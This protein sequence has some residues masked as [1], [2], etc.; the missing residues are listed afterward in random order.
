MYQFP[1][2][3]IVLTMFVDRLSG[4][5]ALG[6]RK[7]ILPSFSSPMLLQSYLSYPSV[8]LYL[9]QICLKGLQVLRK[10]I[11]CNKIYQF[12]NANLIIEHCSKNTFYPHIFSHF[13]DEI[14]FTY[15]IQH[16]SSTDKGKITKLEKLPSKYCF[17]TK[18]GDLSS[19]FSHRN[20]FYPHFL[21]Q[22]CCSD[23]WAIHLWNYTW[24]KYV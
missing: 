18:G 7:L 11:M 5:D 19:F 16:K 2:C 12:Q 17:L 6:V 23:I 20:W 1:S 10:A 15:D 14:H 24:Y 22:C 3:D 9:T 4:L 13:L 8:K 21:H